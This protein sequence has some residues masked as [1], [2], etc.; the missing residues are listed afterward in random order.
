MP[1]ALGEVLVA[2]EVWGVWTDFHHSWLAGTGGGK[3]VDTAGIF[4]E[5]MRCCS[6]QE[7][8]SGLTWC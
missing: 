4:F 5:V 7:P 3:A 6:E 8:H 1:K 2:P